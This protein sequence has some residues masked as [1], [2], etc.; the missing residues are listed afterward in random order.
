[1]RDP[2]SC[3]HQETI[4]QGSSAICDILATNVG[5]LRKACRGEDRRTVSVSRATISV[6][7]TYG[8]PR[9]RDKPSRCRAEPLRRF[10]V[11]LLTADG[12]RRNSSRPEA[13]LA[14]W[15]G[16]RHA[17]S[18]RGPVAARSWPFGCALDVRGEQSLRESGAGRQAARIRIPHRPPAEPAERQGSPHDEEG[19]PGQPC[20][21]QALH[22]SL[23]EEIKTA[24][25]PIADA[26]RRV[27]LHNTH[28][29]EV[30]ECHPGQAEVE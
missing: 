6:P 13:G 14:G 23:Q 2:C 24:C 26:Q 11:C 5:I 15:N 22:P 19:V 21:L 8:E 29:K 20:P 12:S 7:P 18:Y 9:D 25:M 16:R 3:V 27:Q 17:P 10:W 4:A 28:R 1:M 30:A